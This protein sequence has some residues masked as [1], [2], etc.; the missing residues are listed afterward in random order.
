L[1]SI[2]KQAIQI[3]SSLGFRNFLMAADYS[4]VF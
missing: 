1:I 3:N 2:A 4:A